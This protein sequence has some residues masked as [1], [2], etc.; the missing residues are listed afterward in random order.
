M[1]GFSLDSGAL[2]GLV[3]PFARKRFAQFEN[4]GSMYLALA[5][6]WV[7]L[8]YGGQDAS[9]SGTAFRQSGCIWHQQGHNQQCISLVSSTT[10]RVCYQ[11]RALPSSFEGRNGQ[12]AC[13][14]FAALA[15]THVRRHG[16]VE[17]GAM[18]RG[19]GAAWSEVAQG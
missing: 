19:L 9:C 15:H 4:T 14:R 17:E 6:L 11:A 5:G 10:W 8:Q 3:G 18:Q 2:A 13:C 16:D 1:F 12:A 7:V